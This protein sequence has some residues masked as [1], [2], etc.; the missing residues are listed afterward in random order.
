M[1]RA[2]PTFAPRWLPWRR[3]PV[4]RCRLTRHHFGRHATFD[5]FG[6]RWFDTRKEGTP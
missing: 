2:R 3:C 6:V 5:G 1:T 4:R